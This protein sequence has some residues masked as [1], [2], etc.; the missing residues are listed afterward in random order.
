MF[1]NVMSD[2]CTLYLKEST[3]GANGEEVSWSE[4]ASYWC[5]K[6][7]LSVATQAAYMQ[8]N[9]LVTDRFILEGKLTIG[10]GT[11]KIV[12][13]ST[14]YEPISSALYHDNVTEVLC[15]EVL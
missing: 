5:R 1:S 12:H 7:H 15:K 9:T 13:D 14:T 2:K 8:L 11:H 4:V 6:I 3:I 10:L